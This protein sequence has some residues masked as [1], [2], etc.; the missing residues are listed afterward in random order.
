MST[1]RLSRL[2]SYQH[3]K[4]VLMQ[5]TPMGWVATAGWGVAI[6]L[7]GWIYGARDCFR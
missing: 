5:I 6:F 3:W 1:V 7:L 2:L 4:E